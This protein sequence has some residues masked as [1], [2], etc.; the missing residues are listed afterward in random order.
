[1]L[2]PNCGNDEFEEYN[3]IGTCYMCLNCGD[4]IDEDGEEI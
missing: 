2:C 4:I 1:M 3:I